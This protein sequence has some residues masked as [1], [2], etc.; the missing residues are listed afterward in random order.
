MKMENITFI[1]S[2][3]ALLILL[4]VGCKLAPKKEFVEDYF[5]LTISKGLQGF[6]AVCII[7]HHCSVWLQNFDCV[8]NLFTH[9]FYTPVL[10]VGFF[11]FCSGY[12]LMTSLHAK[13]NYLKGFI[14]KRVLTVLVP[15]FI[16][17]YIYM[18]MTQL[19]GRQ[20][21]ILQLIAAFFGIL[22]INSQMWFA[23]EIMIL[24]LIFYM[25]FKK[26]K[27]E[28]RALSIMG[29]CIVL[30]I[31]GSLFLG[32]SGLDY[33]A[34]FWFQGE[35]W[36]NTTIFFFVGMLFAKNK[37]NITK[38]L[39]RYYVPIFTVCVI[40]FSILLWWNHILI[41]EGIYWTET[42]ESL[43]VLDK[44]KG[45]SVQT[46]M[47]FFFMVLMLLAMMK[48]RIHNKMLVFLG[49]I[50]L[51]II[52]INYLFIMTLDFIRVRYGMLLYLAL[53]VVCTLCVAIVLYKIKQIILER[54]KK[55]THII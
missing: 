44:L 32:H 13:D 16:C 30:I 1:I 25:L 51:E 45:L 53:V 6:F 50:S 11:F 39:Q 15:F 22:L 37:T 4:G 5:S 28:N 26:I 29:I 42:E 19:Y 40:G 27:N 34:E 3:I 14:Q 31:T 2:L 18:I 24:Y 46:P 48:V 54:D 20:Y 10:L 8:D 7:F 35:W 9:Y 55:R 47:V 12:E 52:L 36:Y 17:N 33:G 43:M 23:I 49:K 41:D 21:T 38:W